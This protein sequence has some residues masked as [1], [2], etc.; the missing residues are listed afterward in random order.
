VLPLPPG[1][2]EKPPQGFTGW[3]GEPVN[4]AQREYWKGS[5]ADGNVCLH[6]P[7]GVLGLDVDA[8]GIKPGGRC[9]RVMEDLLGPL[10]VTWM[11]TARPVEPTNRFTSGIRFFAVPE[12][13]VPPSGFPGIE[14]I[15]VGHRYSVVWSSIHPDLGTPYYWY[16]GPPWQ[17]M[18]TLPRRSA[19]IRLPQ[20]WVEHLANKAGNR[21]PPAAGS[22]RPAVDSAE[23]KRFISTHVECT[24]PHLLDVVLT[25]AEMRASSGIARHDAYRDAVC[26]AAQEAR[27][28]FYDA[29]SA[30]EAVHDAFLEALRGDRAYEAEAEW[31][32]MCGWA[33][34]IAEAADVAAYRAEVL[35][36]IEPGRGWGPGLGPRTSTEPKRPRGHRRPC[37]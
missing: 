28:G 35:D 37:R 26:K 8:Y 13:L 24:H 32:R 6:L 9:L 17:R 36:R 7:P 29:A 30:F 34:S 1:Q 10:P 25:W 3:R 2:K 22:V 27:C 16:V 15:H 5:R 18:A 11:A 20:P 33:V 19:L 12:G 21:T 23:V 14:M 31:T 4:P